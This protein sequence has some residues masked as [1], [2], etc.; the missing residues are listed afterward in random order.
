[1]KSVFSFSGQR[2]S[3]NTMLKRIFGIRGKT[4]RIME[5]SA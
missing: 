4:N 5:K 2:V 3:G 1:M